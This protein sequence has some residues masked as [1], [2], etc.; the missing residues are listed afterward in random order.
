MRG[1]CPIF[2]R[3]SI[4]HGVSPFNLYGLQYDARSARK[5]VNRPELG[6]G[7]LAREARNPPPG[8]LPG[9]KITWRREDIYED[10]SNGQR[11][12]TLTVR[13]AFQT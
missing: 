3:F 8:L 11:F 10:L 1:F 4:V 12:K 6:C 13:N 9:G 7:G 2:D 5:R